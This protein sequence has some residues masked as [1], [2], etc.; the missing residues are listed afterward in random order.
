[1]KEYKSNV[2]DLEL[3]R[4]KKEG[5]VMDDSFLE[6]TIKCNTNVEITDKVIP[7]L[8]SSFD[9][10]E[11]LMREGFFDCSFMCVLEP[12]LQM[13]FNN[14]TAQ[15][16][17]FIN[18]EGGDIIEIYDPSKGIFLGILEVPEET[19][20]FNG[21]DVIIKV[22]GFKRLKLKFVNQEGLRNK[23]ITTTLSLCTIFNQTNRFI[24]AIADLSNMMSSNDHLEIDL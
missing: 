13:S 14:M 9:Q 24:D 10:M 23:V 7:S 21:T 20:G 5:L 12:F 11:K 1:M 3:H 17:L 2:E 22:S 18:N 15:K 6:M 19:N 4:L 16:L 8:N